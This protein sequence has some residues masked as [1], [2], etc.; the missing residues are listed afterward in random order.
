[1]ADKT[2]EQPP[3]QAIVTYRSFGSA[4]EQPAPN[5]LTEPSPF[6]STPDPAEDTALRAQLS[7][8]LAALEEETMRQGPG[9]MASV[10]NQFASLMQS[11]MLE[12][13]PP[14]GRR[15]LP[16]ARPEQSAFEVKYDER[17]ILGWVGSV[18]SWWKKIVPEPWLTAAAAPE[19]IGRNGKLRLAMVADWGTGLYGAPIC[20][21][22]IQNDPK[23]IDLLLHLGDV[24]YSGTMH[25]VKTRFLDIWPKR[26]GAVSR[27]CNANHEMY[28]G[29][30]GY[31]RAILPAFNQPAS[32]FALQTDHWILVGLDTAYEDHDLAGGQV[33]WLDAIVQNA[34]DRKV[35]LF[36]H[37]QPFSLL[38]SQGPKLVSKLGHLL[39]RKKIFAWYWGHEHRCVLYDAHPAWGMLGRC[40]GHG[41]YPYFRDH[42]RD[43]P[44]ADGAMWRRLNTKNLVPGALILDAPNRYVSGEEE[45]YGANGYLTLEFDGAHLNEVVHDPDGSVLHEHQLA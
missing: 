37:H 1:M 25:E 6:E 30:E 17:D 24:Y 21:N 19:P 23:P 27:A 35:I 7:E 14:G 20:A 44:L 31:F 2:S 22:S 38:D 8:A 26:A 32:Y 13:P 18:F 36:S 34:G 43:A 10:Q 39:G 28:T 16:P 29:G 9:M 12:Q 40:V 5:P 42:V 45:K 15:D 11:R 4:F 41:G 33:A 3:P